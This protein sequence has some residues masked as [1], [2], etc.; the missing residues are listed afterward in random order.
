MNQ[1][2]E[3]SN[4]QSTYKFPLGTASEIDY[5]KKEMH[6][7]E[8]STVQSVPKFILGELV[9]ATNLVAALRDGNK[10][11]NGTPQHGADYSVNAFVDVY[12]GETLIHQTKTIPSCNNPIWACDTG[13]LFRINLADKFSGESLRLRVYD[14]L[15]K[16]KKELIGVVE[17][18]GHQIADGSI[19]DEQRLQHE[20]IREHNALERGSEE[21]ERLTTKLWDSLQTV[22]SYA[23]P[24]LREET[25][26]V[27]DEEVDEDDSLYGKTVATAVTTGTFKVSDI[28]DD[29]I[30]GKTGSIAVRFRVASDDDIEFLEAIDMYNIGI[31]HA[32]RKGNRLQALVGVKNIVEGKALAQLITERSTKYGERVNCDLVH[33]MIDFRLKGQFVDSTGVERLRVK[34]YADDNNLED[35]KFLSQPEMLEMC[36]KPSQNWVEAGSGSLGKIK[37]EILSCEGLPNKDLVQLFGNKTDPFVSI[38]YEDCIC[39][40]DY[41]SDCLSPMWMPWTQ[42]AFVFNRMHALSS[43]YVGVFNHEIGPFKHHGCGRIAIDPREFRTN[44]IYTLKYDLHSSPVLSDRKKKGVITIRLQIAE[45][46]HKNTILSILT[47]PVIHVNVKRRKTLSVARYI[48]YGKKREDVYNMKILKSYIDEIL[49]N[50]EAFTFESRVG[51][52]SLIFWRGQLKVGI[53]NIPIHSIIAFTSATYVIERPHLLP[54]YF[55]FWIAWMMIILMSRKRFHPSPWHRSNSFFHH[56]KSIL[57]F[58]SSSRRKGVTI[59]PYQGHKAKVE[60]D[61]WRKNKIVDDKLLQSKIT[62]VREEL[63]Q[64]LSALSEINLDTHERTGGL[65]PLSRLLPVQLIL[66]DIIFY[67][68]WL[69]KILSCDDSQIS[70]L[71]TSMCIL[72]GGLLSVI[73]I[74]RIF[75]WICRVL[76]WVFLGPWMKLVDLRRISPSKQKVNKHVQKVMDDIKTREKKRWI[77]ARMN[78]EEALKLKATRILRFGRF[79]VRVPSANITR[80][81][82]IPLPQSSARPLNYADVDMP[83]KYIP[84]QNHFG[85]MIPVAKTPKAAQEDMTRRQ[86]DLAILRGN[87]AFSGDKTMFLA[88][89]TCDEGNERQQDT[90]ET[91]EVTGK[92]RVSFFETDNTKEEQ[93]FELVPLLETDVH[94]QSNSPNRIEEARS[95]LGNEDRDEVENGKSHGICESGQE[96]T[97]TQNDRR[98]LSTPSREQVETMIETVMSDITTQM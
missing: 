85:V 40:T 56:L 92:K 65:N 73:P 2:K 75:H 10:S 77:E 7:E 51:M 93:G 42:R 34:P 59:D 49:E 60:M 33:E 44:T 30:F 95:D 86:K 9:G 11:E 18:P 25:P 58:A 53:F 37:V 23:V 80:H 84:G 38:V 24:W 81:H 64:M 35:T 19:C 91:K 98:L 28:G 8:N 32:I 70:F 22:A 4:I 88:D 13:S 39:Q 29:F 50:M 66:R 41:L 3:S 72:I 79:A 89:S 1:S 82:D 12:W 62:K 61:E 69:R 71:M 27:L 55:F 52:E 6:V 14:R 57:P 63:Q 76:I 90:S 94:R 26:P 96:F 68:R 87:A 83:K 97:R 45:N 36:H 16:N 31:K 5:R 21:N 78:R 17:I 46:D 74:V 54:A 20:I 48:C 47:P 43:I 15:S 67:A